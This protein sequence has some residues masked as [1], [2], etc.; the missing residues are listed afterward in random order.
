MKVSKEITAL[1][2]EKGQEHIIKHLDLM[3]D[4]EKAVLLQ[5]F[6]ILFRCPFS[7]V[8]GIPGLQASSDIMNLKNRVNVIF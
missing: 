3:T 5:D 8:V 6:D 2:I 7:S 1:L 4:E